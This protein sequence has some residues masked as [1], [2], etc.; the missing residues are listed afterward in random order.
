MI[1]AKIQ[2]P[3]FAIAMCRGCETPER[4]EHA[5]HAVPQV[6]AQ[7]DHRDDVD[8]RH[9]NAPEA[10]DEVVVD[11]ALDEASGGRCRT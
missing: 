5:P 11:V 1:A 10:R 3:V 7:E 9:R 6:Q 2:A 4:L 8:H